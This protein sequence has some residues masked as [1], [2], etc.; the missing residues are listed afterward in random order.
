[1]SKGFLN[2]M[3]VGRIP[4]VL[5]RFGPIERT[6]TVDLDQAPGRVTAEALKAPEAL[7]PFDRSLMDGYAVRGADVASARETAPVFLEVVGAVEMGAPAGAAIGS[8]QAVAVPTGAMLPAG[9]DAVVMIEH[10]RELGDGRIEVLKASA[11]GQHLLSQGEDL[12]AGAEL[13]PA[14]RRLAALDLGALA[15][16][17]L[18]R[19]PV[20]ARP[21]VAILSTGD[22]LVAPHTP[23]P[24]EPG[25]VRD[26]N[27]STL[28]AQVRAAG[29]QPLLAGRV[30]DVRTEL[31]E[32]TDRA[33]RGADMVLLSGGSSVGARD[34]TASVL[35]ELAGA[36]LL[37]EGIALSPGKPTL[38]ADLDGVPAFGMPGHPVSSFVVF[39]V[40]VRDLLARLAGERRPRPRPSLTGTLTANVP[41]SPG[42]ETWLRVR[43]EAGPSGEP[44]VVPVPGTSAVYTSLLSSD[45][46]LRVPAEQE[47]FAAGQT[48]TVEV[49]R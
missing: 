41:G 2:L 5:E 15:A 49:L 9:A 13:L 39:H 32:A 22:E 18:A 11:P 31:R 35:S 40:V 12:A 21:T 6:E 48:V 24:L 36:D 33:R 44:R 3:P 47:G 26:T 28:A 17:G 27:A 38:L 23:A 45:G 34:H 25:K 14:G 37:V 42:R 20:V 43:I 29:G 10:T 7:P 30:A 4:A 8:G 46:L 19:I 1:M 16:C